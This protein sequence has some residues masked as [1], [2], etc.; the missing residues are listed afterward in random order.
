MGSYRIDHLPK[1]RCRN[2]QVSAAGDRWGV[3]R[4]RFNAE[5]PGQHQVVLTCKES[6]AVLETTFFVQGDVNE[7]V[8][9]PARP[10]VLEEISRIT[11][12]KKC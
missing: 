3:F 12:G 4:G 8:G 6:N 10:E 7:P 9:K 11:R 5:E 2:G 1:W